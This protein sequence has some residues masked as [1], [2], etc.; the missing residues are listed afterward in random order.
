VAKALAAEGAQLLI[1]VR[2]SS[3][4]ANIEG[5]P[6]DTHLGDLARPET[7]RAALVGCD[8]LFMWPPITGCGFAILRRCTASM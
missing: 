3:N 7:L 8:A 6:G 5:I 2:K 4:L 1:L